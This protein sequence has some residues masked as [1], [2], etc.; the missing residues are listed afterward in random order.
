[1]NPTDLFLQ[2]Y[3][4]IPIYRSVELRLLTQ[5]FNAYVPEKRPKARRLHQNTERRNQKNVI[6]NPPDTPCCSLLQR[7]VDT[8]L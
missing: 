2:H 7:L 1:W 4:S 5:S 8:A 3:K 6:E